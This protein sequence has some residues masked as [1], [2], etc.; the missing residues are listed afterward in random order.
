MIDFK[1]FPKFSF[2]NEAV[3][4]VI[5]GLLPIVLGILAFLVVM[6]LSEFGVL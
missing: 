1:K 3:L 6:L 2:K 5:L 4:M